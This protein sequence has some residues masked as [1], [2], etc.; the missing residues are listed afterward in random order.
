MAFK[1][2]NPFIHKHTTNNQRTLGR[3]GRVISPVKQDH[4]LDSRDPNNIRPIYTTIL[5]K[6]QGATLEDV[7]KL[8]DPRTAEEYDA[9]FNIN[10]NL[11]QEFSE[12]EKNN[13]EDISVLDKVIQTAYNNPGITNFLTKRFPN[14]ARGAMNLA[15]RASGGGADVFS[16]DQAVEELFGGEGDGTE[17]QYSGRYSTTWRPI[18]L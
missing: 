16:L 18:I 14:L 15:M 11:D 1:V 13:P 4:D 17:R 10:P 2:K 6:G 8:P 3:D 5:N 12:F 9:S 7:S